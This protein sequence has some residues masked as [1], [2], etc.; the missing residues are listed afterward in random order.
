[1][2]TSTMTS[3]GQITIPKRIREMLGLQIHDRVVFTPVEDGKVLLTTET[4]SAEALFGL[5]K[6]KKPAKPVPV[7]EMDRAIAKRRRQRTRR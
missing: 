4:K 6:H 1:M 7:E 2:M 5:L 3:K